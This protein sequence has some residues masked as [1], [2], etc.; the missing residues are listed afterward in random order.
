MKFAKFL[1]TLAIGAGMLVT[2][3]NA[4]AVTASTAISNFGYRLVDL[5]ATD[6]I[7]PTI[8][9]GWTFSETFLDTCRCGGGEGEAVNFSFDFPSTIAARS[10]MYNVKGLASISSSEY[11]SQLGSIHVSNSVSRS[12]TTSDF[13]LSANTKLIIYGISNGSMTGY[14]GE[15]GTM[16]IS[17][18]VGISESGVVKASHSNSYYGATAPGGSLYSE[19]F[20]IEYSNLSAADAQGTLDIGSGASLTISAVPEPSTY[21]MLMAGLLVAGM[22]ARRRRG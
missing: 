17:T 6:G 14:Q 7:T 4:S 11:A 8:T 5:D 19:S 22:A 3:Q 12:D 16:G 18:Y 13:T 20:E 2:V 10:E 9:F 1:S 21:A 15:T